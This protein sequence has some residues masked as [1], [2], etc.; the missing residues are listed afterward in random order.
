VKVYLL[1]AANPE[2]VRMIA[3]L[4]RSGPDLEFA[5]L[6]ND[7]SKHGADF[8]GFPVLGGVE[9]VSDLAG[10]DVVFVNLI[11]GSTTA[12]FETSRDIVRRG[13][14]LGN[15]I[16]PSIDLM[17]TQIGLGNYLQEAVILQAEVVL[18]NNSSIHMGTLVGHETR[19][20]SSVFVAH[21]VSISG[22]CEIGDGTFIGT[23]ASVLPRVRIGRWVTVG[24]GCVVNKDVPDYSVIVGNPGRVIRTVDVPYEDGDVLRNSSADG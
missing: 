3:A 14:T 18:G 19:I 17:M 9:R 10:D 24:A 11:T 13:G 16:H 7:V 15:F 20:G 12:R 5:L 2:T 4:R 8:Y 1:G 21:G 6:D 23:N 22:C